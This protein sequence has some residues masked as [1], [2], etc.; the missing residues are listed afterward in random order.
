MF[1]DREALLTY[2]DPDGHW[3]S[4][5]SN[6]QS[7]RIDVFDV[8]LTNVANSRLSLAGEDVDNGVQA[9]RERSS[10]LVSSQSGLGSQRGIGRRCTPRWSLG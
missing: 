10:M 7:E 3:M 5:Y 1:A 8:V 9:L 4:V 6:D 2:A